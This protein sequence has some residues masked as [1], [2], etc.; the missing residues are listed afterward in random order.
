MNAAHPDLQGQQQPGHC[1]QECDQLSR[2]DF[3]HSECLHEHA[4]VGNPAAE[5]WTVGG[6]LPTG[7]LGN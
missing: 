7:R 5:S 3:A 6:S 2:L 1:H 4:F